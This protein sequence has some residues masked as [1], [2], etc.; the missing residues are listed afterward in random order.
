MIRI[1]KMTFHE[2]KIPAFLQKFEQIKHKIR[3]FEG[4]EH[5]SLLRDK[6]HTNVFFTY[7]IWRSE[8][9]L[10]NYR[11]SDFFKSFWIE[12]KP[13]FADKTLAWSTDAVETLA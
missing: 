12:L 1:V 5:L 8:A 9:D 4:V 6:H 13:Y 3:G 2:E 11:N 10:E 7:S